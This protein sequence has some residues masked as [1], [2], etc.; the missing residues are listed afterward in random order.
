MPALPELGYGSGDIGIIEILVKMESKHQAQPDGHIGI[1]AKIEVDLEGIGQRAQPRRRNGKASGGGAVKGLVRQQRNAVGQEH[2]LAKTYDESP[3]PSCEVLQIFVPI[4]YFIGNGLV[5]DDGPG[6]Q[7]REQCN[8]QRHIQRVFLDLS[9]PHGD[10]EYIGHGL[11]GEEGNADGQDD[12]GLGDP[13]A[14]KH[15]QVRNGKIQIFK[16]KQQRQIGD[17]HQHQDPL[18]IGFFLL[19]DDQ[20]SKQVVHQNGGDHHEHELRL[21][22]GIEHQGCKH[23]ICIAPLPGEQ[24]IS[25]NRQR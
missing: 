18:P 25:E 8:V 21:A 12:M 1:A 15:I 10:I 14:K 16:D 7:L 11:K 2:F 19:F 17:D 13:S 4:L 20:K 23:Q 24:K 9:A 6:D 5:A 22:P 3:D